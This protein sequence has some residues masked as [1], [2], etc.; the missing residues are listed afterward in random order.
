MFSTIQS[1]HL[2]LSIVQVYIGLQLTRIGIFII[3]SLFII[4]SSPVL[5]SQLII[6][7]TICQKSVKKKRKKECAKG[8]FSKQLVVFDQQ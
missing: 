8:L 7:S 4:Y 5:F 2:S 1:D 6:W 3:Y